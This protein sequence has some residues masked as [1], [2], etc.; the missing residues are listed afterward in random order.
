MGFAF[1]GL[2]CSLGAGLTVLLVAGALLRLAATVTGGLVRVTKGKRGDWVDVSRWDWDDW[3]DGYGPPARPRRE[4]AVPEPGTGM[5]MAVLLL[6]GLAGLIGFFLTGFLAEGVGFR[7]SREETK[8]AVA[9]LN[10]PVAALAL[11]VMLSAWLPTTF[12][13]AAMVVFVFGFILLG[14]GALA[15]M[16]V[17]G[18]LSLG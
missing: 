13:R 3:D 10:L 1:V 8:L 12:W 6:S 9:V 18:F 7:M 5:S 11:T 15:G 14:V 4:R 16:V 2:L 17:L